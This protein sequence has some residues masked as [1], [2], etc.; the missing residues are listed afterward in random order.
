MVRWKSHE[1]L[2]VA[3]LILWQISSLLLTTY[4]HGVAE[5]QSVYETR[6]QEN[7]IPF[8][9]WKNVLLPQTGSLLLMFIVYLL[10]DL[11]V[12]PAFKKISA[13]DIERLLSMQIAKAVGSLVFVS[14]LLALGINGISFLAR[15][16]LFNY[17]EYQFLSLCGYNDS[18]LSN[19]FF[20]FDRALT[21]VV[22]LAGVMAV[23]DLIIWWIE[24]PGPG[25]EFRILVTNN[26]TPGVFIYFLGLVLINPSH[27]E[28]LQYIVFVTPLMPLYLYLMFWLLPFKGERSFFF[29]AVLVRL[30]FATFICVIPCWFI[31]LSHNR[32]YTAGVYWFFLLCVATPMIWI[33]F[34]QRKDRIMQL[35][36]MERAL[37]KSDAS[38]QFLKSQINPHFLFNALNTLYGTALRGDTDK[39]A[40]GIQ[41]L[42]D[43][44]RFMLHENTLDRIPMEK[45]LEYLTNFIALQKLR[46]QS[47]DNLV[48]ED[49][50]EEVT[51]KN[52]I[53]PMLL[54]P[55]VENAFKHGISLTKKSWI[56]IQLRTNDNVLNFEVRNSRHVKEHKDIEKGRSGIGLKNVQDRLTLQY[57]GKHMLA[58]EE[59]EEEFIVKVVLTC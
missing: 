48:V 55:F 34:Q 47:S 6:F 35:R 42:G 41:K 29:K 30:L 26:A 9:Y 1:M 38:L 7:G 13:Y 2:L 40:E 39:T 49:D 4:T 50:I 5:L 16:H 31:L 11:L 54:I 25:R 19:L 36:N 15:P 52:Q 44:M 23:R 43:M 46:V 32:P 3:I 21:G 18:P 28:F 12:L 37:A 24:R 59:T 17:S 14:Y 45:E 10:T 20:G 57:P 27:A 53:A 33:V 56:R 22:I 51:G 58:I 8:I